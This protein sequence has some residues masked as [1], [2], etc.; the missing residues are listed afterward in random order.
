MAAG[1]ARNALSLQAGRTRRVRVRHYPCCAGGSATRHMLRLRRQALRL[2]CAP[3]SWARNV[4]ERGAQRSASRLRTPS[5]PVSCGI[6][7][8]DGGIERA[9]S[10][11]PA[12]WA[13]TAG[14]SPPLPLLRREIV[15]HGTC[16]DS[17]AERSDFAALRRRGRGMSKS[18]ER[19][20]ARA[21]CVRRRILCRVASPLVMAESNARQASSLQAGRK[22]RVR[23][24][25]YPCCAGR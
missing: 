16:F 23:V 20:E 2:R 6:T 24:R 3:S 8:G 21:G 7:S 14:A 12:G 11:K 22:R 25:H 15:P 19:S 4:E 9:P 17:D 5:H 13:H 18:A 10:L 1:N